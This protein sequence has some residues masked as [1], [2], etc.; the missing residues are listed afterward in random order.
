MSAC[1]RPR[2]QMFFFTARVRELSL[3]GNLGRNNNGNSE[4]EVAYPP[5]C[6]S[7]TRFFGPFGASSWLKSWGCVRH[8]CVRG[9]TTGV[10]W[11]G[12]GCCPGGLAFWFTSYRLC[13]HRCDQEIR[14]V[15]PG[16]WSPADMPAQC[17]STPNFNLYSTQVKVLGPSLDCFVQ[18]NLNILQ[19]F[20]CRVF[21][22]MKSELD[23]T[24]KIC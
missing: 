7:T 4:I 15:V 24:F 5:V 8:D 22:P 10:R 17:G 13:G 14:R 6:L 9:A 12:R 11:Y 16:R 20:R 2:Q 3:S 19:T 1:G 23:S 18:F 21:R